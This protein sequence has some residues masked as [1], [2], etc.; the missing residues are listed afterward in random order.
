MRTPCQWRLIDGIGPFF[1]GIPRQRINWSKIA[2]DHIEDGDRLDPKLWPSIREDFRVFC[3]RIKADGYNAVTLDD[4]AHLVPDPHYPPGLNEKIQDYRDKYRDLFSIAAD[5]ELAVFLTT[6]FLF[7]HPSLDPVVGR[8]LTKALAYFKLMLGRLFDEFPEIRGVI[9]RVGEAD[10]ADAGGDFRSRLLIKSPSQARKLLRTL[11]PMVAQHDRL[12]V[13]RTWSVGAY[14]V[15]DL[16]WNRDTYDEVFD[17]LDDPHLI[18]SI[19]YGE[20]DFFRYLPLNGQFFKGTQ[21]KLIEFQARREYE[22]CGEYPS[23]VGW[24]VERYRDALADVPGMVGVSVWCQTGGWA[25]FRRRAYLEEAGLWNEVNA[26]VI[27]Q[28]F[29]G[30]ATVDGALRSFYRSRFGEGRWDRFLELMELSDRVIKEL[31]Y[32]REFA[33][34]NMFFR[35]LRIPPLMTVF[36][37]HLFVNHS[38]RKVLQ[39]LVLDREEALREADQAMARLD[40]MLALA[41]ELNLRPADIEFQRRTFEL[42]AEARAYYLL[43]FDSERIERLTALK[44]A[45]QQDYPIRYAVKLDFRPV[46]IRRKWFRRGLSFFLRDHHRYRLVDHIV[47]I[48]L[49]SG[50]YGFLRLVHPSMVPAFARNR[51]MGLDAVFK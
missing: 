32:V 49:L 46:R 10:G 41:Q 4:V 31:L 16:M 14:R 25:V 33:E 6:D 28:L 30:P 44:L 29:T 22:G 18:V 19:K 21:Q 27:A 26:Y 48:R 20:S 34:R 38:M 12:L 43:P 2:F 42:L 47:T 13:F 45:Y 37:D 40:R 24:D 8:S 17:G 3:S 5:H 23:F 51:A 15:G 11:L 7:S 9:L 1:H 50:I 35:R 39:C 36:W